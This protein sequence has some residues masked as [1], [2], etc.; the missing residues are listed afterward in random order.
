M[1]KPADTPAQENPVSEEVPF[2]RKPAFS[3]L[4]ATVLYLTILSI[5]FFSALM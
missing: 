4:V 2:T 1:K 3:Y 5:L